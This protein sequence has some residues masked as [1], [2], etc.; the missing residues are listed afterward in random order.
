M[1]RPIQSSDAA[2]IAAIYNHYIE[3]SAATFEEETVTSSAMEDRMETVLSSGLPWL[4]AEENGEIVGYAYAKPWNPR[5]AYRHTVEVSIYIANGGATKGTG[6][7]LYEALF[8]RLKAQSIRAVISVITLPNPAS[9]A[10]HE[11]FGMTQVGHFR[12]VGYKFGQWIDVGYWQLLLD[13]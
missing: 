2:Q 8:E 11:K 10:I 12:Q 5:T 1:I 4:V 7:R 3:N 9:V 13:E 6:S